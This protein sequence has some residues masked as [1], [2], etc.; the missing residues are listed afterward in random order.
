MAT[1]REDL[2]NLVKSGGW[3]RFVQYVQAEW[4]DGYPGK[5]KLAIQQAR[6]ESRD[7]GEAV[8]GVDLANDAINVVMSWPKDQLRK[9]AVKEITPA[10]LEGAVSRRGGL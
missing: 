9:I 4:K 6:Q 5:I 8:A 2:E 7:L 3:L 10:E 1:E